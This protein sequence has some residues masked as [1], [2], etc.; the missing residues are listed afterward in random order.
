MSVTPSTLNSILRHQDWSS[1]KECVDKEEL[2][3]S[4]YRSIEALLV[5]SPGWLPS[6]VAK[7][8]HHQECQFSIC[9][10]WNRIPHYHF[11]SRVYIC[12][13]LGT[14]V[15]RCM[16]YVKRSVS[17]WEAVIHI[18]IP[19]TNLIG[20]VRS[21]ARPCCFRASMVEDKS[22]YHMSQVMYDSSD[23]YAGS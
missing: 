23:R 22:Q 8:R 5:V 21:D 1:S 14:S 12:S 2:Y 13:V 18:Y 10:A 17:L 4:F 9:K 11:W 3:R 19:D 6:L 7:R 15:D 20:R 16:I